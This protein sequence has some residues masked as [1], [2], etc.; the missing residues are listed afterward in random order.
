[1]KTVVDNCYNQI[2]TLVGLQQKH[3]NYLY[4]SANKNSANQLYNK[5]VAVY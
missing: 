4:F 5:Y 2:C 3:I 1:M